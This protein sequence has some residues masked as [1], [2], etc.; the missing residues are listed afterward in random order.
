MSEA[1]YIVHITVKEPDNSTEI[2]RIQVRALTMNEATQMAL[3]ELGENTECIV[4]T[5]VTEVDR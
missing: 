2:Y 3:E 4:A 1:D 5:Q